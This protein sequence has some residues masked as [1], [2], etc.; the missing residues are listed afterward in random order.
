MVSSLARA[1]TFTVTPSVL[2]AV[3]FDMLRTMCCAFS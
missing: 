2:M 3:T 1:V